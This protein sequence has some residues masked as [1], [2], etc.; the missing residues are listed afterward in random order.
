MADKPR[1]RSFELIPTR[2][3]VPRMWGV[4]EVVAGAIA[5]IG[6]LLAGPG[7]HGASVAVS[8]GAGLALCGVVAALVPWQRLP[9]RAT[10]IVPGIALAFLVLQLVFGADQ[11]L[12]LGI[13][14][15][16]A[17]LTGETIAWRAELRRREELTQQ[18]ERR[19]ELVRSHGPDRERRDRRDRWARRHHVRQSVRDRDARVRPG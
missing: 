13:A 15:W 6:A 8:T 7:A 14:L 16:L 18:A 11:L 5:V 3:S 4:L 19:E 1:M 17:G 12:R 2:S 9:A 10:L